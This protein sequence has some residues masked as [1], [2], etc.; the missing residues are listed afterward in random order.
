MLVPGKHDFVKALASRTTR[1][2]HVR[3]AQ[4]LARQSALSLSLLAWAFAHA[5]SFGATDPVESIRIELPASPGP[6]AQRATTLLTR[7][8]TERSGVTVGTGE[9]ADLTITLALDPGIGTE[10]FILSGG[11]TKRVT[12]TGSDD[13]GLLYGVGRFLRGSNYGQGKFTPTSWRG[14]SVPKGTLRG[15]YFATHFNNWHEMATDAERRRYV[16]SLALWG[17]NALVVHYPDQWLP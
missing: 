13:K 10:G 12:I 14:T 7:E 15:I 8:I 3:T 2:S 4:A 6:V 17:T 1:R 11:G 5:T 9:P 16:E